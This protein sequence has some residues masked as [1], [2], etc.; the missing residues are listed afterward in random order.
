[1]VEVVM[2]QFPPNKV[3][4][5]LGCM[6]PMARGC[7]SQGDYWNWC[8][9]LGNRFSAAVLVSWCCRPVLRDLSR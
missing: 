2:A 9:E 3:S 7:R 5:A 8:F 4:L 6:Y 1:M